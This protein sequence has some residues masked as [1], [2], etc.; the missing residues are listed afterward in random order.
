MNHPYFINKIIDLILSF[1]FT[2]TLSF[3]RW[4]F[5]FYFPFTS[6]PGFC[7][8]CVV[9][10][11][12]WFGRIFWYI[13]ILQLILYFCITFEHIYY[14]IALFCFLS[15]CS[16]SWKSR[17]QKAMLKSGKNWKIELKITHPKLIFGSL[18]GETLLIKL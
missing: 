8:F 10:W 9:L 16:C 6:S 7:V 5:S 3:F 18:N 15:S 14:W 17:T 12:F 11:L 4:K 13:C 1:L 2:Q